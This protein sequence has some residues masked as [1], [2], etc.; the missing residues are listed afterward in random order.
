MRPNIIIVTADDMGYGDPGC[1][2]GSR[3]PT[4]NI[5]RIAA[6]GM[7]FTDMH[8]SAA[9]CTP[10]RYS[11]LTGRYCWRTWLRS[12]VL[13][14]FGAPVIEPERPTLAS[15]L[16]G[17][18]YHTGAVG[19]WHLGLDWVTT[20]GR[21]VA[22]I[23]RDGWSIDG[24]EVDYEAELSGGPLDRGFEHWF[25]IAGSLDMPP[26]CFIENR[27]PAQVPKREKHPY[28]A[29]QRRG[30]MTDDWADDK[31]DVRFAQ[32]ARQFM[33]DHVHAADGRPF[34]LYVATSAPHR[35]CLPPEFMRGRSS[36]GLRGDMV[37][38][39]DWVI[40]EIIEELELNRLLDNTLLIVTS[41]HGA[42]ATNFNGKD[43]AHNAN[44]DL[45]GQKGDIY[46]GGHRV[47]CVALWPDGVPAGS[48]CDEPLGHVDLFATCAEL[49]DGELPA[50]AE[51]SRS[52]AAQ[53]R[54]EG[55]DSRNR[56]GQACAPQPVHDAL[57]HR[58][59]DGMFAVRS[60]P[61]KLILG[62]GS[63]GNSEPRRYTPLPDQPAGQ[64]YNL[65]DDHRETLNLYHLRPDVVAELE[66]LLARYRGA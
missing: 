3:V 64:L 58:S 52:F 8:A 31:V 24:F 60:G 42:R 37:A 10:S 66:A 2:G 38:V 32:A 14:G 54:S 6:E 1:Y 28:E 45:R 39:Y 4:P 57:I 48:V 34:F 47:P 40:G 5:D 9:V 26:Y 13:G 20:A 36:A 23:E 35:P 17:H 29:Q 55:R 44:G 63:G 62:T 27:K 65:E 7:R 22:E 53:L 59:M 15:F 46:E 18:G 30:L 25:G 16:A 21:P 61:W 12:F 56:S 51:D 41:D 11:M 50:A 33:S 49:I 43:Y 19:K